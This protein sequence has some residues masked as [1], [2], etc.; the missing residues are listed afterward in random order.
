MTQKDVNNSTSQCLEEIVDA[1]KTSAKSRDLLMNLIQFEGNRIDRIENKI[2]ILMTSRADELEA[3]AERRMD[4]IG[5]NGNDGEHYEDDV[6]CNKESKKANLD[7]IAETTITPR[8]LI[9]LGF[10]EVYQDVDYGDPG[11]IFYTQEIK[12]VGFYSLGT[13]EEDFHVRMDNSDYEIRNLRKL[14]DLIL[15]LNEL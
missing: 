11:Y 2:D 15:S 12:G 13:D 6:W 10:E 3:E 7:D 9:E 8:A 5:Q 14:G 1:M 4:I